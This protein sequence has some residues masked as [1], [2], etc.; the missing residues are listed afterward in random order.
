[1]THLKIHPNTYILMENHLVMKFLKPFLIGSIF[2]MSPFSFAAPA[3]D[4]QIQQL[5]KVM[6]LNQLMQNTIQQIRPQLDQQ[7][8]L[9]IQAVVGHEKLSPQEQIVA[10]ELSD[11]LYQQSLKSIAWEQMQPIYQKIYKDVY[12]AEEVQAQIN[13]YSSPIGQSILAKAPLAT[14]E[15]MKIIN[16]RLTKNMQATEADFKDIQ[17]KIKALQ[18]AAQ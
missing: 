7:A 8:Y 3:S 1:M 6:N 11:K 4:Q 9:T 5:F 13:F 17:Q 16:S 18:Q 10:N 14:Q 15:S 12:S 2:L